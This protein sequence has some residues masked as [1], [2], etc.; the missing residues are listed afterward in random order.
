MVSALG[1]KAVVRIFSEEVWVRHRIDPA[2]KMRCD[3]ARQ[4][5]VR[6]MHLMNAVYSMVVE[7]KNSQCYLPVHSVAEIVW[8]AGWGR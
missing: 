6:R 2:G 1:K 5:V 7:M 4:P 3:L 8:C